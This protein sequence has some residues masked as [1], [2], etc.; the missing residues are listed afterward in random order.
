[1]IYLHEA[2]YSENLIRHWANES[3][4]A[5]DTKASYKILQ[6][7]TGIEYGEAIDLIPCSY[8]YQATDKPIES[9]TE[10]T[11]ED[12]HRVETEEI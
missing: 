6:V 5:D 9:E 4:S 8:T 10:A 12:K 1:M 11:G 3:E 7:E 2:K